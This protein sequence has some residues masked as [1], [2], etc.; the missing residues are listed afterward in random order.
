MPTAAAAP[1]AI[2]GHP[3][4]TSWASEGHHLSTLFQADLSAVMPAVPF[5]L[6]ATVAPGS[7][8]DV[9]DDGRADRW[10]YDIEWHPEAGETLADWPVERLAE[11][12]RAASGLPGLE[13]EV[14]GMF[15]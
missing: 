5:V 14:L 4:S 15:T 12:I 2:A 1:S 7:R 3:A 13:P 9:R 11:R 10:F 6:T 8:G